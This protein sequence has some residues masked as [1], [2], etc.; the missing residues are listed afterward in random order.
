MSVNDV[1]GTIGGGTDSGIRFTDGSNINPIASD[2]QSVGEPVDEN[3]VVANFIGPPIF[4]LLGTG[5]IKGNLLIHGCNRS[6]TSGD[7]TKYFASWGVGICT[8][9]V[10]EIYSI[11]LD[12]LCVW[13]GN[14]LRPESGGEVTISLF[15]KDGDSK[16]KL[17]FSIP[18][19]NNIIVYFGTQDHAFIPLSTL[20]PDPFAGIS[21]K[22]GKFDL[23]EFEYPEKYRLPYRGLCWLYVD[24]LYLGDSDTIPT[25]RVVLRKTPELSFNS[26][27]VIET[28]NYNPAHAIWYILNELT[29]LPET[30]LNEDN[31][32][33]VADTLFGEHR[34]IS[35]LFEKQQKALS[36]IESIN[37]HI[38]SV[39]LYG[40]DGKVSP[41]LIRDDYGSSLPV[42]DENVLLDEPTFKR[43]SWISTINEMKVMYTEILGAESY[44]TLMGAGTYG[45][46][47]GT[48]SSA[49]VYDFEE[50]DFSGIATSISCNYKFTMIVKDDGTLWA[51]GENTYGQLGL[52]DTVDRHVFTQVGTDVDWESVSSGSQHT[53]AIKKN[54]TIWGTGRNY[55]G[56]LGLGDTTDRNE[57]EQI[58]A[59]LFLSYTKVSVGEDF[60]LFLTTNGDLYGAGHRWGIG[61]SSNSH[62]IIFLSDYGWKD[63][64][65]TAGATF[66]IGKDG[67]LWGMGQDAATGVLGGPL[68][69]GYY[70]IF[71][72]TQ[73]DTG[74]N[75]DKL[76]QNNHS[77][78]F[79]ALKED[80]TIWGRGRN[81][82]YS[83]GLGHESKTNVITQESTGSTDWSEI[84][85]SE[86]NSMAIK[87]DGSLW[88]TGNNYYGQLGIAR[89]PPTGQD[90]TVFTQS[91]DKETIWLDATTGSLT[92][93]ALKYQYNPKEDEYI[94][95]RKS[96]ASP[97]AMDEGNIAVQNRTV[98]KS[99]KMALFTTN[100]N[101]VW[102]GRNAL[103][104]VSYPYAEIKC[105]V[106]RNLFRLE[107]GDCFYF[108][109]APY[110]ISNMIFRVAKIKE[111]D[112]RSENIEI[113]AVEDVFG[114]TRV[115]D[116]YVAP[117]DNTPG[118]TSYVAEPFDYEQ[119]IESPYAMSGETTAL[120]P[121]A[122]RKSFLDLGFLL[123]MSVDSGVSYFLIDV[124]PS[125]MPY[126]E[127]VGSYSNN[128]HTIDNEVGFTI[129][130]DY[131][132]DA[133]LY[134]TT[135]FSKVLSGISNTAI[136]GNELMSVQT[137][138]PDEYNEYILTDIIRGRYGTEK[139]NHTAGEAF[140]FID[141]DIMKAIN[142]E[143]IPNVTR[144]FKLVP[145][146][147]YLACDISHCAAISV[148]I[149]GLSKTPY[150]PINF[151]ANDGS[152]AAR[153]TIDVVLTWSPRYRGRGAGIGTPGEVLA[154][155]DREGLFRIEVWVSSVNVRDIT[156]ID[157]DTYTYTEAM[158][159]TDNGSLASSITFKLFN[160]RDEEGTTY[161][162]EAVTVVCKKEL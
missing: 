90:K 86:F 56:Q 110:S 133:D 4:D 81:R 88:G 160:F 140:Y 130:F 45:S 62:T 17:H 144:Q 137:I 27:N 5:S 126:G 3:E 48:G 147:K 113:T 61:K 83:L 39:I 22:L 52:G 15:E 154:T 84:R 44:Y 150:K 138:T 111:R 115:R 36:Y 71:L 87:S 82:D 47:L 96:T 104:K 134:E 29:G 24:D 9:P 1:I 114:V 127:L 49:A 68:G 76:P 41:K 23:P 60:S 142:S 97:I 132:T 151:L 55:Y 145:Y 10:D 78:N 152:Y 21:S 73:L 139:E 16:G 157:S 119:I 131:T 79:L 155:T 92:T 53:I 37:T 64:C 8:G 85:S 72:L 40:N 105:V 125:L 66:L 74:T 149:T 118:R 20:C 101:A 2:V 26:N 12:D 156:N 128:T 102:A 91:D 34:G 161:E 108:S 158:N 70:T 65:A 112:L 13:S 123:Y 103:Q 106:N 153:Y 98:S 32:S 7:T 109:Y 89:V 6:R 63:I 162:S 18:G 14:L 28:H 80:G 58:G 19:N 99:V 67:T 51:S 93:I 25:I 69:V 121:M 75:W 116:D 43:G 146:N 50:L 107:V 57:F 77:D 42:I 159:L 122:G 124:F 117:T 33:D 31:F 100:E 143:I 94:D 129:D 59:S 30:W 46:A 54:K 11:W 148:D 141:S 135:T 95:L 35:I 136:L 38:D 120:I